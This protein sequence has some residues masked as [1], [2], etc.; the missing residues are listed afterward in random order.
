MAA[1]AAE[2]AA[3]YAYGPIGVRLTAAAERSAARAAEAAHRDRRDAL[4]LRLAELAA[5]A[6]PAPAGYAL[7]FPV[8]DRASALK[9]AVHIED[10]VAAAWRAVLPAA[11]AG[12][13][14]A[15][16]APAGAA[17]SSTAA[18]GNGPAEAAGGDRVTAMNALTDAAVQATRWRRLAGVNPITVV[19]PGRE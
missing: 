5:P 14:P 11:P 9:L 2:Y 13:A 7:P 19:F 17:P 12:P 16:P 4:I 18:A 1:L 6:T 15:G 8:T 10:R 3:I